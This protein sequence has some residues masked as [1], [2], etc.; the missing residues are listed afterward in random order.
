MYESSKHPVLV[1]VR[2]FWRLALHAAVTT[3]LLLV[4]LLIGMSGYGNF[5]GLAWRDGFLNSARLLGGMGPVD[6]PRADGG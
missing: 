4:S 1:R 6:A 5:E 2:F 3:G